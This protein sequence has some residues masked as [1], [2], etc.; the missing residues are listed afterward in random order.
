MHDEIMGWTL[1]AYAQTVSVD[2]DLDL[3]PSNVSY[4]QHIV[5]SW[6]SFLPI[7]FQIPPI[8]GM[9]LWVGHNSGMH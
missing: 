9:K 7:N 3:W 8:F 1:Y 4:A 2:C 5:L 6:L